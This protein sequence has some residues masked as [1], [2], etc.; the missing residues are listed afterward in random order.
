[1]RKALALAFIL[2][3]CGGEGRA[4]SEVLPVVQAEVRALIGAVDGAPEYLFG[5]IAALALDSEGVIYVADR[6]G[7]TVRAYDQNGEYLGTVG[8][9]G[10][11]P[12]EF[13][14]LLHLMVDDSDRL[15]V[16]GVGRLTTL[17]RSEEGEYTDSVVHT[18]TMQGARTD[19]DVPGR[20]SNAS[21]YSPGYLW[22]DFV[23]QG[24]YYE[25]YDRASGALADTL[26]VPDLEDPHSTG[27]ANYMV[28]ERGGRNVPGISRAP[29]EP[30]PSWDITSDGHIWVTEGRD[31][32]I[33][34]VDRAGD[35]VTVI[36]RP[37]ARIPVPR[38]ELSDSMGQFGARL[39]SLPV[40]LDQVRGM[41][42]AARRQSAAGIY[43]EIASLRVGASGLLWIGRWPMEGRSSFDVFDGVTP[44]RTVELPVRLSAE[45][46][47]WFSESVVVGVT[48][49]D[50]TGVERVVVLGLGGG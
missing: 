41:S 9:E 8:S 32:R 46:A 49:D 13:R 27:L 2:T 15:L 45:P 35:T 3:G 38:E 36:E 37:S 39:D 19:R 44:L 50:A 12:G 1:M 42:D 14:R 47:P 23:R 11:G 24:Y 26:M 7:S 20:V 21:Y 17:Q 10:D 16:R 43:P 22:A 40:A 31:Y 4:S 48:R 18:A 25:V 29:F 6:L 33:V 30:R 5:D 34:E 28:N